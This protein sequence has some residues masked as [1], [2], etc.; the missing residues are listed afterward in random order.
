MITS[1]ASFIVD[2]L[3]RNKIIEN[4]SEDIYQYGFEIMIS[5]VLTF[6]L[7]LSC[8]IVF[9]CLL[10]SLIY[11]LI[12]AVLRSICGGYHA[13]TYFQC[14]MIFV[15]VTVFVMLVYKNISIEQFTELH[16]CIIALAVLVTAFYA[17]IENENKLL[18][19]KQKKQFRILGT[20]LV[21]LLA[22]TSCLLKIKFDS[23]YSIIIDLTLLVVA[24]SIFITEPMRGGEKK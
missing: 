1:A 13:R 3:L 22:L 23:D 24:F 6:M 10:A 17:P 16:Y 5:S 21:L 20:A 9:K 8:G 4:S 15:C 18:T 11:F 14:N 7:A 2:I 19:V 12:F